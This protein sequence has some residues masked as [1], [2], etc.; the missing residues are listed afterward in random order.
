MKLLQFILIIKFA[1]LSNFIFSQNVMFED[2]V[3][4]QAIIDRGVDTNGDGN[5]QVYEA[6]A[7]DFLSIIDSLDITNIAGLEK[8]KNI[9]TLHIANNPIKY[10][11]GYIYQLKK[12]KILSVI[13]TAALDFQII[14]NEDMIAIYCYDNPITNVKFS[15]L[16]KLRQLIYRNNTANELDLS[17]LVSVRTLDIDYNAL[18][19]ID[20]SN[21]INLEKINCSHNM[22][23]ELDLSAQDNLTSLNVEN[24]NLSSI[25]LSNLTQL[26]YLNCA[27]NSLENLDLNGLTDLGILYCNENEINYLDLTE[28]VELT[29]LDCSMN[30]LSQLQLNYQENLIRLYCND[31]N[32]EHLDI[33]KT[34]GLSYF[35]CH[36]NQLKSMVFK[37]DFKE[38]FLDFTNN[39]DLSF[40]C[41]D[42][43]EVS[44][45]EFRLSQ[46]GITDCFVS[47]DCIPL[48]DNGIYSLSGQ[49]YF[50]PDCDTQLSTIPYPKFN[51]QEG[52]DSYSYYG[53]DD[54]SF[55]F[56]LDSGTYVIKYA[57]EETDKFE[58]QPESITLTF[59]EDP[60]SSIQNFCITPKEVY[61][62]LE[63]VF[64]PQD[65]A[66]PGFDANYSVIVK[67]LGNTILPFDLQI[68]FEAELMDFVSS[69]FPLDELGNGTLS[70]ENEVINPFEEKTIDLTFNLNSPTENPPLN[71][72]D[73]LHFFAE[74]VIEQTDEDTSNNVHNAYQ[75]VV[76]SFDPNDKT[77]LEGS[78]LYPEMVG[79]FLHYMIR[80][81]NLGTTNA[82]TI[83]IT[84]I[85]DT[86]MFE[87]NTLQVT[88]ASHEMET[89]IT[90]GNRVEFIFTNINLPFEDETNDGKV[91]FKMKT[92]ENLGIGVTLSNTAN[93]YFDF[94]HP[95]ITN[96][97]KTTIQ[98]PIIDNDM[99]GFTA[100]V[101]CNDNDPLI[102]PES[103][104]ICDNIDNNCDGNIDEELEFTTYYTDNDNDGY[105]DELTATDYCNEQAGLVTI[106][107]DCDDENNTIYPGAEEIPNNNIDE[108][109][110]GADLIT[111]VN[112]LE[113]S[114][115]NIYPNPVSDNLHIDIQVNL[116]TNYQ[117]YSPIGT[118]ILTGTIEP[119]LNSIDVSKLPGSVYLL[120]ID[121]TILKFIKS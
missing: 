57:L 118:L 6:E 90:R 100:D 31:N 69:S 108:D 5:I 81:E 66:Q 49:V 74:V 16:P 105:G 116:N 27:N 43:I 92:K 98:S 19:S 64:I 7:I 110:D 11:D 40:I 97:Y 12:L 56:Y 88:Y 8:F 106:S 86:S 84:D 51:I 119:T 59:P 35:Y 71:D 76:N 25:D 13:N 79:D 107:G 28:I 93:I 3:F 103:E 37:N 77:C 99:D 24:N 121:N 23:S 62:D 34:K 75:T 42:E 67:N 15:N 21:L 1:L 44:N 72:G 120:R 114:N 101:D 104:E 117:I 109:C 47:S 39:P 33:S 73:I 9:E 113:N 53:Y 65:Q 85:I 68:G 55:N 82:T 60:L 50:G 80:F 52:L 36:N 22:I 87:I 18:T 46:N 2:P 115:V 70:L 41:A 94:N 58:V 91:V 17:E 102:H 29:R 95:I 63:V 4:K 54:G 48:E 112:E 45:L 14:N 26:T 30:N 78:A 111:D 38:I 89:R 83:V 61:N 10:I 96:T 20:L 32:L